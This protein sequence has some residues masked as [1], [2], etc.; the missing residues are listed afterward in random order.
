MPYTYSDNP[1][2]SGTAAQQRDA[3]RFLIQDTDVTNG[4][5]TD[6]QIA[7]A[8][9]EEP[10]VYGAAARCCEALASNKANISSRSVGDTSIAYDHAAYATLAKTLRLK[11]RSGFELPFAGGISQ[12]DKDTTESSSDRT[13]PDFF[14]GMFEKVG[15]AQPNIALTEDQR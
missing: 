4:K 13:K 11:S 2:S 9:T 5:V 7:F 14:R 8:L 15:T 3:V 6:A 1:V 10:N 12:S